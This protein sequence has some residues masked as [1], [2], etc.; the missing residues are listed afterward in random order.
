MVVEQWAKFNTSFS[1]NLAIMSR[2]NW[3]F[4]DTDYYKTIYVLAI[5]ILQFILKYFLCVWVFLTACMSICHSCPWWPLR[6]E[7][8]TGFPGTG[9]KVFVSCYVG[10]GSQTWVLRKSSQ[11]FSHQVI[12]PTL[13]QF[14]WSWE[15]LIFPSLKR[16]TICLFSFKLPG[17]FSEV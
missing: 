8:S 12:S 4:L 17:M 14:I 11:C 13:S 16:I 3:A 10:T 1:Y 9:L 7:K 15:H 2:M 5:L 6:P